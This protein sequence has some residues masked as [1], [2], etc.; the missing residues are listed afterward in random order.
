MIIG[1]YFYVVQHNFEL[2]GKLNYYWL[3]LFG[4]EST[5]YRMCKLMCESEL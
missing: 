1:L 3:L 2:L 5:V 4:C